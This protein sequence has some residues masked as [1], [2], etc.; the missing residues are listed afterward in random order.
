MKVRAYERRVVWIT[1]ASDGIGEALA[2]QLANE[3]AALALTA[4]RAGK[5]EALAEELRADGAR[6]EAFA[7]DVTDAA[8]MRE[9][10]QRIEERWGAIDVLVSN[11]GIYLKTADGEFDLAMIER[12][13]RVN[14][15]GSIYSIGAALEI[16]RK[17]KAGR[18]VGVAS[19]AGY[20]GLPRSAA[21][22][23]SKAGIICW[24]A[25]LSRQRTT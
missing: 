4:R 18:I 8:A 5:L 7:G 10:A 24:R 12:Q 16:M 1:G 9:I 11:A 14:L 15:L 2:R 21:Y 25:Y 22:G 3:G 20:R 17:Q 23:A 19:L 6:C 13:L